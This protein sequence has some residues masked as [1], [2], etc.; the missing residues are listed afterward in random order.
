MTGLDCLIQGAA[1]TK[2]ELPLNELLDALYM[3]L[4]EHPKCVGTECKVEVSGVTL[5]DILMAYR[6][7]TETK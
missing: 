3:L 4:V 7:L 1:G 2:A 5:N 6:K